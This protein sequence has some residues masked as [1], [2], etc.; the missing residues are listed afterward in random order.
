VI[1]ADAI[2]YLLSLTAITD[3]VG[4]RIR[5]T[6]LQQNESTPA[7][8]VKLTSTDAEHHADGE[9]G[10][11]NTTLQFVCHADSQ[12]QADTLADLVR[13]KTCGQSGAWGDSQV[14]GTFLVDLDDDYTPPSRGDQT[15]GPAVAVT[16]DVWHTVATG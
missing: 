1:R 10:L 14:R 8:A 16:V 6:R 11:H 7:I 15:G 13:R 2:T 3:L 5:P 9:A 4:T 12:D